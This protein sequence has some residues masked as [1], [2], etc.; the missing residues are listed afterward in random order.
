MWQLITSSISYKQL[1]IQ[2]K[3]KQFFFVSL[4][5][6]Y[7]IRFYP[8]F[9]LYIYSYCTHFKTLFKQIFVTPILYKRKEFFL[10]NTLKI[11]KLR[12]RKKYYK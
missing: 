11:V 3:K 8:I 1:N 5:L 9:T 2:L 7:K 6:L 12:T 10:T 4:S